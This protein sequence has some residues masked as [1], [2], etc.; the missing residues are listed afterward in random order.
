MFFDGFDLG[1]GRR[2]QEKVE[3]EELYNTLGVGKNA[4]NSEIKKAYRQLAKKHH[5]DKGGDENQFKKIQLAFE[6]LNDKEKRIIYDKY[7]EAGLRNE[8]ESSGMTDIFDLFGGRGRNRVRKGKDSA[9][10]LNVTLEDIY[11]QSTKKLKFSKNAICEK[12]KGFSC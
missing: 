5:P 9:F 2:E 3:N 10:D 11:N 6:V 8:A 4:T 12:C 7:G 1:S